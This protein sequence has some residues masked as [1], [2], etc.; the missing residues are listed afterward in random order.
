M[1]L[2]KWYRVGVNFLIY[3]K[4]NFVQKNKILLL[5]YCSFVVFHP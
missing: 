4:K 2:S 1:G 5:S 3:I